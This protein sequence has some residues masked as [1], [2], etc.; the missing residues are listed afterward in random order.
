MIIRNEEFGAP[1]N[2]QF[3]TIT[4]YFKTKINNVEFTSETLENTLVLG[5]PHDYDY[6]ELK[7]YAY[8]Q[9]YENYYIDD[10]EIIILNINQQ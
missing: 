5:G 3:Y 8:R 1:W 10:A 7:S 9:I 4:F 6:E 2:D